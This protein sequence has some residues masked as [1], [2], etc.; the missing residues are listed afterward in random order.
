MC[1][2]DEPDFSIVLCDRCLVKY[3]RKLKSD[4]SLS[5]REIEECGFCKK[6]SM[7]IKIF[8]SMSV[9]AYDT[10]KNVT[11][12]SLLQYFLLKIRTW[13]SKG[14]WLF[15]EKWFEPGSKSGIALHKILNPDGEIRYILEDY[16]IGTIDPKTF[17]KKSDGAPI[18]RMEYRTDDKAREALGNLMKKNLQMI[19]GEFH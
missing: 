18:Q 3:K 11:H 2:R 17:S 13:E 1:G 7:E 6:C 5:K 8:N 10:I 14:N 4:E 15:S 9:D 12:G 16:G 19:E